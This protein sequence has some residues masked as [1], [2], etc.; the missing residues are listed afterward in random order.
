MKP[1][2]VRE[3]IYLTKLGLEEIEIDI[4]N[5]RHIE[6]YA[7]LRQWL[8][9]NVIDVSCGC[10][11]G[12]YLVSK[13]P[14]VKKITGV[15]ISEDAIQ[16]AKEQFETD[17]CRFVKSGIEEYNEPADVLLSIETIEHL[18]HPH[19][20]NDLADRLEVKQIF[21][22]YPSKK[23]THYNKHHYRD[24]IDDEI[25]RLFPNYKLQDVIDLH[26]EVRILNLL[27]YVSSI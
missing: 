26:R 13:N 20:L 21:V 19:I 7:M 5:R 15:D 22:S 3:R 17:K 1:K 25:I 18:E 23:T 8:W 16:W 24:F 2:G 14:D 4:L 10:G 9:G 27:R 6:R 12:A 11:Y